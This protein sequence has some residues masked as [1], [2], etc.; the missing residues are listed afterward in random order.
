MRYLR[1]AY[2]LALIAGLMVVVASPAMATPRWVHCIKSATGGHW[3]SGTC[4]SVGTGW[5][6]Q[7]LLAT[8]EV[9]SNGELEMEDSKA[10][11]GGL[12][13][14]CRATVTG[15][16]ANPTS[17]AGVDGVSS[18]K[19]IAC[20]FTK[21]GL[22]ES[23]VNVKGGPTG[24][25]WGGRLIEREKEVRDEL[26]S[27]RS[28]TPGFSVECIISGILKVSDSCHRQGNT[29]NV[30]ANRGTGRIEAIFD[31]RTEEEP[32]ADCSQGGENAGLVRGTFPIQLRSGN[33]L[34]VLASNL[35][36]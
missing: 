18:I 5:E 24:L 3:S 11:E 9:T 16:V 2:G 34:W 26:V 14:K 31:K 6:T 17:G 7:E 29:A 15:W 8:S 21:K 30:L 19:N 22:C 36:T 27:G 32:M 1:I 4:T 28:E 10:L 35:G 12:G 33:A 23:E 25:P 13:L 20:S